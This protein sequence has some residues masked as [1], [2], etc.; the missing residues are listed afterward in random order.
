MRREA[1][2]AQSR[3]GPDPHNAILILLLGVRRQ[4]REEQWLHTVYTEI[5]DRFFPVPRRSSPHA[6]LKAWVLAHAEG[7]ACP[8]NGGPSVTQMIMRSVGPL[9]TGRAF[10]FQFCNPIFGCAQLI[11]ELLSHGQRATAVLFSA[12]ASS[13]VN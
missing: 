10:S 1:Q 7:V 4:R 5:E 11:R 3:F 12:D 2:A 13:L 9:S 8:R 6:R